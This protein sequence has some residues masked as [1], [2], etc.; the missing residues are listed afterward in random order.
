MNIEQVLN[1]DVSHLL[2]SPLIS[3]VRMRTVSGNAQFGMNR[4]VG[5][6]MNPKPMTIIIEALNAV[7]S[8][9]E[10]QFGVRECFLHGRVIENA[11][12]RML[13]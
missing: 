13:S 4:L 5:V 11:T 6:G 1:P 10:V 3:T 2:Y 12:E 7:N 8:R 9:I